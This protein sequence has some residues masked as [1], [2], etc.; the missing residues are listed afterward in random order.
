MA[1]YRVI[2]T[3]K[4]FDAMADLVRKYKLTVARHTAEKLAK[5][6]YRVD[7][8]A[9]DAQIKTLTKAG[10]K[11]RRLEDVN[12]VGK[13]RQTEVR[14]AA[15][16]A[17]LIDAKAAVVNRYRTVEEIEAAVATVA[18]PPNDTFTELIALPEKSWEQRRC[19]AIR[20]GKGAGAARPASISSAGCTRANGAAR[21][22]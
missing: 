3:G 5:A 15:K 1:R 2:I 16:K 8:Y 7:A 22:S 13:A 21:T 11:V 19:N 10:Y 9:T 20:I 14:T 6:G 18:D 17:P 4:D 12:K